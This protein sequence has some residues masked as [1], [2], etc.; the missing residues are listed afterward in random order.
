MRNRKDGFLSRVKKHLGKELA[1]QIRLTIPLSKVEE[2]LKDYRQ[3][4]SK[5]KIILK[6]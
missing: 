6:P 1:S 2:A 4:M 5:G 3:N